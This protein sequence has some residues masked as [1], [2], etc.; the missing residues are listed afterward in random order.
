VKTPESPGRRPGVSGAEM[1]ATRIFRFSPTMK[2]RLR[3]KVRYLSIDNKHPK[4]DFARK[5]S[6][7]TSPILSDLT[8]SKQRTKIYFDTTVF[9][10]KY[11]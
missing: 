4:I 5:C 9:Q 7:T 8:F 11:L 10:T 6:F 2:I 3:Q 1:A